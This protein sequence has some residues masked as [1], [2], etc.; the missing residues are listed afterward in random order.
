MTASRTSTTSSFAWTPTP[1]QMQNSRLRTFM[2]GLGVDTLE[3][4]NDVA[5]RDPERFWGATIDDI[6]IGW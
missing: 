3:E 1:E 6:G 2:T 5:R 4:L